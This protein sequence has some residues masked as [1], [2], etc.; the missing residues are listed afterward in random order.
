MNKDH[1]TES[2][3]DIKKIEVPPALAAELSELNHLIFQQV[4]EISNGTIYPEYF[5]LPVDVRKHLQELSVSD[6]GIRETILQKYVETATAIKGRLA[7]HLRFA[8]S[9]VHAFNKITERNRGALS[10][11]APRTEP[12]YEACEIKAYIDYE[13]CRL[14]FAHNSWVEY[15]EL[16]SK[17][18]DQL[19]AR[20]KQQ[21]MD[22]HTY[23]RGQFGN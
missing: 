3:I 18:R 15:E 16:S 10:I 20:A 6:V 19:V 22:H 21:L 14:D 8:T 12:S 11:E 23:L 13:L 9:V 1:S 5:R 4:A 2:V 17:Q 7:K